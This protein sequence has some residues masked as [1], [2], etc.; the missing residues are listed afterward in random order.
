MLDEVNEKK[1]MINDPGP[2]YWV[3]RYPSPKFVDWKKI[4]KEKRKELINNS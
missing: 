4:K 3:S 2:H 1:R